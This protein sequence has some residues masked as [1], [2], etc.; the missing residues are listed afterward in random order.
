MRFPNFRF[1]NIDIFSFWFGF[2]LASLLWWVMSMLRPAFRQMRANART[3]QAE[4]KEK[5]HAVSA[6]EERYRQK[7]LQLAQ[8]QHLAAP[9][10]ALDEIVQPPRLLAPPP[11]VEPGMPLYNDDIVDATVPYLPAWPELAAIY[12][13]PTL[14]LSEALS[15]SS[16]I[17]LVGQTGMGKT[18]TLA[19]LASRLARRDPEPSLPAD[20]VPFLIHVADLGLPVKKDAPLDSLIDDIIDRAPV[21]DQSRIPDFVRNT[22][23]AGRALLLL[24]GTDELTPEGLKSVVEFIR[25]IKRAYP[26]TRMVTT[27]S[28]EYL[29]GLV[30]LNFIPFAM[31]N[32]SIE[33][34]RE[35]LERWGDLWTKY[36]AVESW[37][38]IADHIDPLLINGWLNAEVS[39]LTPLELTLK[40]W[41]CYAGDI[42]GPR[43]LDLL[44]THI[45]RLSPPNAPREALELLAL[46]V[47]LA[48]EPIFEPR[49]AREWIRSLEPP[50]TEQEPEQE[51]TAET[52][53]G[54]KSSKQE[55]PQAP[56]LGLISKMADSGLLTH[57]R[58]NRLRFV[59][60]IF[61]GYLAGKSLANYKPEGIL[62]QPPWIGKFLAMQY[63]AAQGD[64]TPLVNALMAKQDRPLSRNLLTPARW[65]RDAS[66]QAPWRGQ[67]MA[68]LAELMKQTGQP[69][70]LRGQALAAFIQTED[71]SS[72]ML[73]RQLLAE[74]DSE[75]LQLAALGSGAIRDIRAIEFL[76]NM[77]NSQMPNI[78]RAACLA[79]TSI[80]TTAAMDAVASALLH[81]DETLRRSAAEAMANHPTDGHTMLREG[82]VM[83]DDLMVRRAVAYGLG[84]INEP[85]AEELLKK[86][87][88]EDEQWVVRNT[89]SEVLDDH[90]KANP[91]I[92][93][94]LPP[95]SESAWLIAFASKHGMGISP[96]KPPVELLL[97]ALKS[98]EPEERL[99][100]LSY[101]R[102]MPQEGVFG[103]LFQAMYAGDPDLREAVFHTFSEMAS[104]GV[105]VP[106]PVQF[107]VGY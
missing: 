27:A 16:D 2:L 17:I 47:T 35:Y 107:G 53:K 22:F 39:T 29:D 42:R 66:R 28:T 50:E 86:L 37:A 21:F 60:P 103:A 8:G 23:S 75:L 11:R 82:A 76:A 71:P 31:A 92:P 56:S 6:I 20:T 13:A 9:L 68:K 32:W 79:L 14:T 40:A 3:R 7:I 5:A 49:E 10:F 105:E 98:D 99:A 33:Q 100:A 30:S 12:K 84:R 77:L 26:K 57:H 67:V 58:N 93:K 74:K 97:K 64:A 81:G 54:R 51:E 15:G 87:Q 70:S 65:L 106:D 25:T 45:R 4:K 102:M 91:H 41:G 69:L 88:V 95:P 43:P 44:E 59:H 55:K 18:V 46:Q 38:Q 34:R 85:W 101:L 90:Q 1:P 52:K 62:D 61:G 94:R 24:D 63:L 48:T 19:Y 89:A 96:D 78:R 36:V 80:G 72:A 83:K 104:R 73:F